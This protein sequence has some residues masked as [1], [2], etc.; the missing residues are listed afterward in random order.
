[1]TTKGAHGTGL[2]LALVREY[3]ARCGG[4]VEGGNRSGGG[5]RFTIRLPAAV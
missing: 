2:G 5:A 3:V 1:V 4:T